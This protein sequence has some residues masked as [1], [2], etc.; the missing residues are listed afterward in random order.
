MLFMLTVV[1]LIFIA[2]LGNLYVTSLCLYYCYNKNYWLFLIEFKFSENSAFG[3][4][5]YL[6]VPLYL[7]L[8]VV[9]HMKL[10]ILWAQKTL[11]KTVLMAV[12]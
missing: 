2:L 5:P 12:D 1:C 4:L 10:C 3:A 7:V 11:S 6:C 9:S 8:R